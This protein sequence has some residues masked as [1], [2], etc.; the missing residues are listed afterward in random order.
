MTVAELIEQLLEM[1]QDR[2]VV[3]PINGIDEE[4]VEVV[5]LGYNGKVVIQ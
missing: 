2:E 5:V 4:P 3:Y 1:D